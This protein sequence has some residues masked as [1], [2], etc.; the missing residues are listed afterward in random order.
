MLFDIFFYIFAKV[1]DN[2]MKTRIK[3]DIDEMN[4]KIVLRKMKNSLYVPNFIDK[5]FLNQKYK[6]KNKTK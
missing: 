6:S 3:I 2:I 1:K 5:Y 4:K